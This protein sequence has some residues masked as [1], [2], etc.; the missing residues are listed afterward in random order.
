MFFLQNSLR[1]PLPRSTR[2]LF[3]LGWP[4]RLCWTSGER[5][6]SLWLVR[7]LQTGVMILAAHFAR[8]ITR[9]L[10]LKIL[11][12]RRVRPSISYAVFC[13]KKK[14]QAGGSDAQRGA[15]MRGA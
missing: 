1:A 4:A 9:M 7:R 8:D 14:R 15:C 11:S 3:L 13:L 6:D 5:P 2:A 10:L 12:K